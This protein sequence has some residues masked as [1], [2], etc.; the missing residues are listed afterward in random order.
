MKSC[1]FVCTIRIE[2]VPRKRSANR[3]VPK[4]VFP[5]TAC[6]TVIKPDLIHRSNNGTAGLARYCSCNVS[7][8]RGRFC[9]HI[10]LACLVRKPCHHI[11]HGFAVPPSPPGEGLAKPLLHRDALY[12]ALSG[13]DESVPYSGSAL[14]GTQ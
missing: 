12:F 2:V 1:G 8:T 14:P 5:S 7:V 10:F 6:S 9:R 13:T 11:R 4:I 3:K